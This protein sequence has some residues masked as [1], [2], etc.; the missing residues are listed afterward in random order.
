MGPEVGDVAALVAKFTRHLLKMKTWGR[1]NRVRFR[2][3][4]EVK[5]E[6]S[7]FTVLVNR[8]P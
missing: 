6:L 1:N 2:I 5:E 4:T 8:P 7:F 3:P